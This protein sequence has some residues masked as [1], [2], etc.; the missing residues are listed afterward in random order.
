LG[1][2]TPLEP[3]LDSTFLATIPPRPARQYIT[4]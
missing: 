4:G 1:I 3:L 2:E